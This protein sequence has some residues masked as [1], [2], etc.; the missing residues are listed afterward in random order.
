MPIDQLFLSRP[1]KRCATRNHR[2]IGSV[3]SVIPEETAEHLFSTKDPEIEYV[4]NDVKNFTKTIISENTLQDV[5]VSVLDRNTID[6]AQM[7]NS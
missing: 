4:N 6:G 1:N 2:F 3:P 5:I 7:T